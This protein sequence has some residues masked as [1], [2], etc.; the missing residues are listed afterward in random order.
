MLAENELSVRPATF[1][2]VAEIHELIALSARELSR[3]YYSERQIEAALA[4][5]FG[6]D[7]ALIADRT[8]FVAEVEG[9]ISGCG[10]WSKRQTLFG[11]DQYASRNSAFS[12]PAVDAAKIRAFF[13]HPRY[14]RRGLGRILLDRCEAEARAAGYKFAE[15]MSTLPGVNFYRSC[16][17]SPGEPT[18]F[19][20]DDGVKIE[21][22][23]MSKSLK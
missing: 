9:G 1:D 18:G 13:V 2:D 16:G 19:T 10:G 22:V 21:F 23:P 6:V 7:T 12:D 14:A 17:Y 4:S 20:V 5:V 11:G 8:Y 15:L 3:G